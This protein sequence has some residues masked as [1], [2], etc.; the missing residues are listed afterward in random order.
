MVALGSA[1]P[2]PAWLGWTILALAVALVSF[3]AFR[4][5]RNRGKPRWWQYGDANQDEAMRET[6]NEG[7]RRHDRPGPI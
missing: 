6:E 2:F 7:Q 3:I 1:A 4:L 5:W